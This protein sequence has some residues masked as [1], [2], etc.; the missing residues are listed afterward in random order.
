MR[1]NYNSQ[2]GEK[3]ILKEKGI[4]HQVSIEDITHITCDSTICTF[5]LIDRRISVSKSLKL[6]EEE[7]SQFGFFRTNRNTLV[8]LMFLEKQSNKTQP[9]IILNTGVSIP[10]SRRKKTELLS[11][12]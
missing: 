1:I 7:L 10:I 3:I 5:H 6:F 11:I 12:L 9:Q 2:K 4:I 8:N